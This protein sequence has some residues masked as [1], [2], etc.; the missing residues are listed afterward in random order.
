MQAFLLTSE[1][2]E[3]AACFTRLRRPGVRR[4]FLELLKAMVA[5][6]IEERSPSPAQLAGFPIEA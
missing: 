3:L 6:D 5:T 1:G 4:K 2:V